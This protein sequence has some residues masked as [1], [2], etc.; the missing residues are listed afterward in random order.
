M[1]SDTPQQVPCRIKFSTGLCTVT[2][3]ILFHHCNSLQ[4]RSAKSK[5]FSNNSVKP[6]E[7]CRHQTNF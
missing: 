1:Y 7:I 6:D 2:D 3:P 5:K 4:I